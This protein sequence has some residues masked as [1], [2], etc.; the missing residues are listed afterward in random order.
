[1]AKHNTLHLVSSAD[2]AFADTVIL[3][4]ILN[5]FI[6][7]EFW[8]IGWQKEQAQLPVSGLH[9]LYDLSRPMR[10]VSIDDK[11]DRARL[12]VHQTA[13]ELD[14][15]SRVHA[16]VHHHESNFS[17]GTLRRDEIQTEA[18]SGGFNHRSV[19]SRRPGGAG[20]TIRAHPRF[21]AKIHHGAFAFSQRLNLRILLIE[22]FLYTLGV[23]F[24]GTAQRFFPR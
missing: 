19:S 16:P 15:L 22:P 1:M 9:E 20:V 21:V 24:T 8:A 10:R 5:Q 17:S 12:I 6:G 23:S 2:D 4:M 7:V 11:K 3:Q 13:K 14:E 18:L